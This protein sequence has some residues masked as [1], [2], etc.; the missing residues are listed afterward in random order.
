MRDVLAEVGRILRNAGLKI[1]V[2]GYH[3][4]MIAATLV[5]VTLVIIVGRLLDDAAPQA[6]LFVIILAAQLVVVATLGH[7]YDVSRRGDDR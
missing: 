4:A 7:A 3:Q 2:S 5:S 1:A 6:V